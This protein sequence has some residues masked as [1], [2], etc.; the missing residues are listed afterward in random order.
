MLVVDLH[1]VRF[2][3]FEIHLLDLN[4]HRIRLLDLQADQVGLD[5]LARLEAARLALMVIRVVLFDLDRM[6]VLLV[7]VDP[8][9]GRLRHN[10]RQQY[11]VLRHT[12]TELA[13]VAVGAPGVALG[14][15][16]RAGGAHVL[17]LQRFF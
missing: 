13:L 5:A 7:F 1:E 6:I 12:A 14:V 9:G 4:Q 10:L 8:Y 16:R 2:V 15:K 17:L 3:A 11:L